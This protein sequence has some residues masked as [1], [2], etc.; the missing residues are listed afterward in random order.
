MFRV[1][2]GGLPRIMIT[3]MIELT[4]KIWQKDVKEL[5]K[6]SGDSFYNE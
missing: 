2:R 1:R 3:E 6:S 4:V 5:G